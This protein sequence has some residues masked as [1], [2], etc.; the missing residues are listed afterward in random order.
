MELAEGYFKYEWELNGS[1]IPGATAARYVANE[2]G[3]YRARFSRIP[4]PGPSDWNRWSDPVE[5]TSQS[6]TKPIITQRGTVVL[7][8]MD[9]YGYAHLKAEGDFAHYY[10]YKNGV[11]INLPGTQDD[12]TRYVKLA[13]GDCSSGTCVGN[14]AYTLVVASA[15][16]C[17]SPPS[18]PKYVFFNNQA[19]IN[20]PAPTD[21]KGTPSDDARVNLS[22]TDASSSE[23]GFEI[24]R[25]RQTGATTWSAWQMA[26]L[27][28]SDM[29]TFVDQGLYPSSTYQYK[30]RA[31]G[32]AGRSNY[33]PSASN[34]F[35]VVT[36]SGD[37]QNPTTPENLTAIAT[38]IREI[39]LSWE[40]SSD[41]TSISEYQIYYGTQM[42]S[43]G[44]T[45]TTYKLT[46]LPLNS[47]FTFTV[48]AKDLA[49]NLSAPSS[50][51][52]A[53]TFVNGLFYEHSTGAFSDIDLINWNFVEY[54]GHVDNFTLSPRTQE[55]YYNFQF[56]GYLYINNA[57]TYQFQTTSDDGSRVTI[58]NTLAVDND[59]QHGTRTISGPTLSLGAGPRLINV[60]YFDYTG[61]QA[62]TVRYKG[63]DTNNAWMTI[64]DEALRSGNPSMMNLAATSMSYLMS[65][66][67][68]SELVT[69][70]FP[71]PSLPG[72]NLT[73]QLTGTSEPV[74][75]RLLDM[76]G[77]S[78][79]DRTVSSAD[80]ADGIP[81][82]PSERLT[83]GI[84]V[85]MIQQGTKTRRKTL[86]V[87]D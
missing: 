54:T 47:D 21:F 65:E 8:G 80:F 10:W 29:T 73:V 18:D 82:T 56:E 48:R 44:N 19:P 16:N 13:A 72:E 83:K 86:I 71:N 38:G 42:I 87:K 15:D 84:Y 60:K 41:N 46:N 40:A 62:L 2:P 50:P 52:S 36:T 32:N 49:N 85:V 20:I 4:N 57:G 30:I 31:V 26:P 58:D 22:W 67:S 61:G 68:E 77:K 51:A 63:P 66:E 43:T 59:G 55:D 70:I 25:R 35:L 3:T 23:N 33:T 74:S 1:I 45:R 28:P 27:V 53:N 37:S 76:M 69:D 17:P 81:I 6:M 9:N 79:F 64:P 12:T 78:Y 11:L 5:V 34:Q 14:G 7:K 24:W 75:I 39:E